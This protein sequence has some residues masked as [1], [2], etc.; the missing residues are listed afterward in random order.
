M[1]SG[2][3]PL[4]SRSPPAAVL[5]PSRTYMSSSFSSNARAWFVIH[6]RSPLLLELTR[7]IHHSGGRYEEGVGAAKLRRTQPDVSS[8]RAIAQLLRT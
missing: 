4:S 1:V 3:L 8:A 7:G 6:P 5:P 2:A